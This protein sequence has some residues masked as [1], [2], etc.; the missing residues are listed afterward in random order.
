M[1]ERTSGRA[2]DLFIEKKGSARGEGQIKFYNVVCQ[3]VPCVITLRLPLTSE[4]TQHTLQER[5]SMEGW[6]LPSLRTL[7]TLWGTLHAYRQR[8]QYGVIESLRRMFAHDLR[9]SPLMTGTSI[10]RTIGGGASVAHEEIR[11]DARNTLFEHLREG[12]PSVEELSLAMQERGYWGCI[13]QVYRWLTGGHPH[14][15]YQWTHHPAGMELPVLLE[16]QRTSVDGADCE[17][18]CIVCHASRMSGRAYGIRI[19]PTQAQGGRH[20]PKVQP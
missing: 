20:G 8:E 18:P 6:A 3:G 1:S 2:A 15:V 13:G 17:K 9:G 12:E 16:T 4:G 11:T 19:T 7:N 14:L 10:N 5:L